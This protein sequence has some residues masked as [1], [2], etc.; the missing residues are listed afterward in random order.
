VDCGFCS[1]CGDGFCGPGENP[2]TC[3]FDCR[4]FD[5]GRPPIFDAAPLSLPDGGLEP[6]P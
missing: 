1:R 6:I 3:P 5:G 2:F 4:V